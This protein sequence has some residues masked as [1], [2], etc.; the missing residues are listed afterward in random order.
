MARGF[1]GVMMKSF[2]ARDHEA[3]VLET[4]LLAPRFVRIRLVSPTLFEDAV[5]EQRG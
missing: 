1:Q 5:F 3:T 4:V 2:G